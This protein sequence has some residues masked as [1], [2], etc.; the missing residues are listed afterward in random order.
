M[1]PLAEHGAR[2]RA[3]GSVEG[4]GSGLGAW[5]EGGSEA[6][7]GTWRH[8][9]PLFGGASSVWRGS[10]VEWLGDMKVQHEAWRL[11]QTLAMLKEPEAVCKETAVVEG[12]ARKRKKFRCGALSHGQALFG[13][14]L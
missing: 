5:G 2:K 13:H 12:G 3:R 6:R 8:G 7:R 11:L 4:N 1:D 14:E 9:Q 10:E